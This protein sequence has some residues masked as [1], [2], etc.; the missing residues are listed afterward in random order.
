[1]NNTEFYDRLGV[2]K[3][4][5][6]D[7]IKKAYRKMS[8]KYHPDINKEPGAEEKYKEVQE[9]YE[10]LGDEQ[11]RAAYDQYGAAGANGGFG[12]GTG[13]FDGFN[14]GAGFGG[15]EDIFS[16]FF[17]GGGATRNPNAPRQGDD[18]QYRVDLTFEEAVFGVE[19]E[20][21]YNREATCETCSGTGAKPGTSPVTCSRCHGQGVINVDTQTPLGMM[22]RQVTCDVCHGTGKE[23]KDPCP[24]CH[25]SGHEK[26]SH[27][28][29]VKIPA[30]VETGQQ[31][32]LQGQ[33]EAGFNGGPYGDLFVI[34]KVLPSKEF[35]R[36]GST[37][38]Y[39]MNISFV[40]AAL[41]D[42][43]EVPTVHGK[44][45]L[46][47][48]AGTQTGKTFRLRGKGAPKLRG[49]GQ[50]DQH[51][52]VNIV[53]PTKLNPAQVAALKDFAKAGGDK[54]VTLKKKGLFDKAKDFFEGE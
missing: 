20:V 24:T 27:K 28:V 46:T 12:G 25:G 32:R 49:G 38:Y 36:D 2:S 13:G 11:K 50:G 43:V 4:A 21:S 30:G 18:L 39:S 42:T 19:K 22:R 3:D 9:A 35:E 33:G 7:E 5:S 47:I 14:G 16:S 37:I 41:G 15:F 6:Q 52:T 23:I 8:K 31:I 1:M 54:P 44:V 10:T 26:K 45:E 29:S 17:G 40:Q 34:I 51:V 53:T 48:P